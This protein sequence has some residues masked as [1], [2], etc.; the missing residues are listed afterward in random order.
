MNHKDKNCRSSFEAHA[1][2]Y[3]ERGWLVFPCREKGKEPL[4]RNGCKAATLD[5]H[6]IEN[7]WRNNPHA[8]VAI[9]T[10]KD[11]ELFV[12]DI[13]VGDT[14]NGEV[15]LQRL[16]ERF[17]HLPRTIE[18]ITGSGGRHMF[19]QHEKGIG[20]SVS[21]LGVGLDIRSDGGYIIAPPSIHPSGGL[22]QWREGHGPDE[23]SPAP[24]PDWLIDRLRSSKSTG[25]HRP[26]VDGAIPDGKRND[27][28][29][30]LAGV[31]RNKGCGE[32]EIFALISAVNSRRCSPP[33]PEAE[34]RAIAKS[35]SSYKSSGSLFSSK[36][37][38]RRTEALSDWMMR[39]R[40]KGLR[41]GTFRS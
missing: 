9:A 41:S 17:G 21:K 39:L 40:E 10:G 28:L 12:L 37:D 34:V 29:A 26:F 35:I 4:T 22:Y 18:A 2:K 14:K 38:S 19:F 11:S 6:T 7:W 27:A 8:N 20:N 36:G 23:L 30:R 31:V 13:D 5:R 32:E 1:L 24:A 25:T 16:E 3:T 15:S 33:L